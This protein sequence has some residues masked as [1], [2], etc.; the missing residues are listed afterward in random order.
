M[1]AVVKTPLIRIHIKGQIP[2]RI[3]TV[4][5]KEYGDKVKL[6]KEDDDELL[7]VFQTD[8]YKRV[9]KTLT[10]GTNLKIYRQNV[11][12]TQEQLGAK[13]GD[14]PKQFVSNMENGIRPISKKTALRLAK[15][16]KVSVAKFIG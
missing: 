16:F 12:L 6:T 13:L 10:P 3:V 14:L 11:G 7:D 9:K 1:L 15:F 4:L 5:K 8:W 2:S